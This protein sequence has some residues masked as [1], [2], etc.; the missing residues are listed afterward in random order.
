[1]CQTTTI[2]LLLFLPATGSKN[3]FLLYERKMF[4]WQFQQFNTW[5][6]YDSIMMAVGE[7]GAACW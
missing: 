3:Q 5:L 2:S 6:I 1:M 4:G 7:S